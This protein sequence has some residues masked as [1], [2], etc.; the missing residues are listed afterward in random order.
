MDTRVLVVALLVLAGCATYSAHRAT[1]RSPYVAPIEAGKDAVISGILRELATKNLQVAVADRQSGVITV[2][3]IALG[4][5]YFD[6]DF[7]LING[8]PSYL[9][10]SA[11]GNLQFIVEGDTRAS[12]V[13]ATM[14]FGLITTVNRNGIQRV[15]RDTC[16]STQSLEDELILPI[17]RALE[18]AP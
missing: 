2:P 16:Y 9:I 8:Q 15:G 1:P 5:G 11:Q 6:C 13:R 7:L 3:T 17:K 12:S 10:T 14:Q 18:K 4:P